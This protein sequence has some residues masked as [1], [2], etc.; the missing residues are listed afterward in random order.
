METSLP[1]RA[2]AMEIIKATPSL[3]LDAFVL[4][5]TSSLS[6]WRSTERPRFLMP[7]LQ[8]PSDVTGGRRIYVFSDTDLHQVYFVVHTSPGYSPLYQAVNYE[9]H[10]IPMSVVLITYHQPRTYSHFLG[11]HLISLRRD[12]GI[13]CRSL[14]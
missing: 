8:P 11:K 6:R 10:Q 5:W 14:Y 2:P 3:I 1:G 7:R 4:V 13:L 12:P 9:G